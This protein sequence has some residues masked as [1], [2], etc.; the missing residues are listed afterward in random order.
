MPLPS[1]GLVA[2]TVTCSVA[3]AAGADWG[4]A[5]VGAACGGATACA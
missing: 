5:D 2:T 3:D 1:S 4:T